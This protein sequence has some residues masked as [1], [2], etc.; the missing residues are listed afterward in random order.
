MI[1][2]FIP[3]GRLQPEYEKTG[4]PV[5]VVEKKPGLD[6]FFP[7][8]LAKQMRSIKPDIVHT[9]NHNAWLYGGMAARLLN[10]RLVH[11]EHTSPDYN[12]ERWYLI[13]KFMSFFTDRITT[14]SRSVG[15]FMADV[16]GISAGKITVVHNGIDYSSYNRQT[17][18]QAKKLEFGIR[19]SDV[20]VGNVARLFPNKDQQML[21]EAFRIVVDKI[22][23]A[24]LLIAGDGP[25]KNDLLAKREQLKLTDNVSL[26]G[27]RRD[28]VELL[29]VF[30]VFV[31]PSIKE[32]L[33]MTILE[34]M[35]CNAAVI[36]TD[37]DGNPEV[38]VDGETGYIVPAR[39]PAV[40]AEKIIE[41]LQ[42]KDKANLMGRAGRRRV[43]QEFSFGKMVKGYTDVYEKV[44]GKG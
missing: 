9:H 39:K 27:N 3:N 17:D 7:F 4:I 33:P 24:R 2:V 16:E 37:V 36:A 6:I 42:D 12:A 15:R 20:V 1:C 19:P 41:L 22:P 8:R 29:S 5:Y 13:E 26:L 40:L 23:Y 44:L 32:G 35:C 28:I 31:L 18:I 43:E 10:L 25:L 14:V 34:A 38:V 21:L 11:T 30:D